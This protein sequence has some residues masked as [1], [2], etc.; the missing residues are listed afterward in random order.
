MLNIL[1]TVIY[2]SYR[3]LWYTLTHSRPVVAVY[4]NFMQTTVLTRYY[5][6][7]ANDAS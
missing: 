6:R 4:V 1:S 2:H 3:V 7:A 5:R